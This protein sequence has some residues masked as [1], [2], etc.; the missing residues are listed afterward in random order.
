[1]NYEDKNVKTAIDL[2]THKTVAKWPSSCGED[3]PHGLTVDQDTAYLF[4]ACST[5]AEVLDAG[6]SCHPSI[7]ATAWTISITRQA[8]TGYP[9]EQPKT[10]SSVNWQALS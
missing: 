1:M 3:G 7:P 6:R 9:S 10:R 8:L 2:K 5:Q 4:V